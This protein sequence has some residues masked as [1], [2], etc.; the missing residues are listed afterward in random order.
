MK[1][2][3]VP[4]SYNKNSSQREPSKLWE[5]DEP[6]YRKDCPVRRKN[7]NNVHTIQEDTTMGDR[8]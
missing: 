6:Y 8:G 5:Y 1:E 3:E 4:T 2:R 7:I